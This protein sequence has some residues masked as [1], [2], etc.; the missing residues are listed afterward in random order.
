MAKRYGHIGPSAKRSAM[1]ALDPQPA[2]STATGE[3]ETDPQMTD[4]ETVH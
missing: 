2:A 1:L 3:A 4:V